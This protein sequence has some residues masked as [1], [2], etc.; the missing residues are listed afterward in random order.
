M[1]RDTDWAK[2]YVVRTGIDGR[3]GIYTRDYCRLAVFNANT[4]QLQDRLREL[5][6][7]AA[8]ASAELGK[9]HTQRLLK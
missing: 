5:F 2:N 6:D 4:A 8:D 3:V 1:A 7:K 9:S